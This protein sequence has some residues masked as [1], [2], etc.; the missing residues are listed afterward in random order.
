MGRGQVR[1]DPFR[2][3]GLQPPARVPAVPARRRRSP[4]TI[5][6]KCSAARGPLQG[7]SVFIFSYYIWNGTLRVESVVMFVRRGRLR[8]ARASNWC[9]AMNHILGSLDWIL[10]VP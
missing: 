1:A 9:L 6:E 10:F 2:A 3:P 7:V 4:N 5:G 8:I